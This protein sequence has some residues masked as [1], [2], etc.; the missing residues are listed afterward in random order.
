MM[1]ALAIADT[2]VETMEQ[3]IWLQHVLLPY[4]SGVDV[5][6]H[7]GDAVIPEVADHLSGL[8]PTHTVCGESDHLPLR[9]STPQTDI[10][11]LGDFT[12][13]LTHGRGGLGELAELIDG[14]FSDV[15]AIVYGHTHEP[16]VGRIGE[17]LLVN[18]GSPMSED[19][20]PRNTSA[21]IE[22]REMLQPRVVDVIRPMPHN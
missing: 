16:F 11:E 13:G 8:R 15:D 20:S 14:P 18:P 12:I 22:A 21:V 6:L 2:H 9:W 7:A 17:V 19:V 5:I 4:I 10:V 3:L 1:K